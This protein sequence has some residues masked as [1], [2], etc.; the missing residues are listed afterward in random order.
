MYLSICFLISSVK[1]K[2]WQV[3]S[4]TIFSRQATLA[5]FRFLFCRVCLFFPFTSAMFG[6]ASRE[7]PSSK[8]KTSKDRFFSRR[9][10]TL[11]NS[12]RQDRASETQEGFFPW[13]LQSRFRGLGRVSTQQQ[14]RLPLLG[15]R[16]PLLL[17]K[18]QQARSDFEPKGCRIPAAGFPRGP[19]LTQ[20]KLVFPAP[21]RALPSTTWSTPTLKFRFSTKGPSNFKDATDDADTSYPKDE[22]LSGLLRTRGLDQDALLYPTR[23]GHFRAQSSFDAAFGVL[24]TLLLSWKLL[25]DDVFFLFFPFIAG[26]DSSLPAP[27]PVLVSSIWARCGWGGAAR[28][29]RWERPQRGTPHRASRDLLLFG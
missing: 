2:R 27:L 11:P 17:H 21:K 9:Q 18:L 4:F 14:G 19:L 26:V 8:A 24:L 6:R 16:R 1:T 23:P 3:Q 5:R 15:R 20:A 12:E 22:P 7:R 29:G 10:W 25:F 13:G 28:S